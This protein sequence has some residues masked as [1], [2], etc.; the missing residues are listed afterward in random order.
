MERKSN[1]YSKDLPSFGVKSPG[2]GFSEITDPQHCVPVLSEF[3]D[4]VGDDGFGGGREVP[5][6]RLQPPGVRVGMRHNDNPEI[7]NVLNKILQK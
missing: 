4:D 5:L 2:S 1:W 7:I 3:V 6:D